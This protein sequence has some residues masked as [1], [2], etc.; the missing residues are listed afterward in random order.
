MMFSQSVF[1]LVLFTASL[2]TNS[3]T[4]GEPVACNLKNSR[5]INLI[6]HR[7]GARDK[8]TARHPSVIQLTDKTVDTAPGGTTC[9]SSLS[10]RML[11]GL[12]NIVNRGW[13]FQVNELA[14][15]SHSSKSLRIHYDRA[16]DVPVGRNTCVTEEKASQ[17]MQECRNEALLEF[18]VQVI[19]IIALTFTASSSDD[20]H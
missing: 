2:L 5:A 14:G 16:V 8:A 13:K 7:S 6:Y 17:F 9:I 11:E 12:L 10:S 15:G 18:L 20:I 4:T 19:R 1:G 3:R